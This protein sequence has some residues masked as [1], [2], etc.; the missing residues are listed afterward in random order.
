MKKV[1]RTSTHHTALL[2]ELEDSIDKRLSVYEADVLQ[3]F[4]IHGLKLSGVH[5][6]RRKG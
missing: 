6:M 2:K 1:S 5:Q 3:L 4:V